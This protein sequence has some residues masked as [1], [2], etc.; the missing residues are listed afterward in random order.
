MRMTLA[1]AHTPRVFLAA[2]LLGSLTFAAHADD[3]LPSRLSVPSADGRTTLTGYVFMPAGKSAERTPAVV[4]LHG[5]AGAYSA[6]AAGQY[7]AATLSQRHLMWGRTWAAHGYL[8][9]LVD[10]FGPRGYPAGFPRFSYDRRPP[11]LNE[12]TVRPLDA[13]GALGYLR[14]RADVIADRIGLMGWSNG[15]S[16]T[17]ATMA[18]DAPAMSGR[19]PAQG[20]RAALVFY[21]GCGLHGRYQNG[22]KPYAP[23]REFHGT[24]D[25]EV[26]WKTCA[27]QVENGRAQGGDIGIT[28]YR[29]ATHSFDDPGRRRQSEPANVSAK[30]DAT[31]RSLAFFAEQLR[32]AR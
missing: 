2:I 9:L 1:C 16:A 27:A 25:E 18:V 28:V 20:F 29:G 14:T 31:A 15:G 26:S 7:D 23:V 22:L 11:E 10:G 3:A 19:T 24:G 4:M 12:V 21:A 32:A 8:A 30:Q 13:Y 5:R 6:A 17:L